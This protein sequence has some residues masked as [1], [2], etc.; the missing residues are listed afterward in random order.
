MPAAAYF[1]DGFE[2]AR[3]N[4]EVPIRASELKYW[5]KAAKKAI[6]SLPDWDDHCNR[7]S[8]VDVESIVLSWLGPQNTV[9][10]LIVARKRRL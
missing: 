2:V 1:I 3:R 7:H 4:F 8:D 10:R 9:H 6:S 5:Y